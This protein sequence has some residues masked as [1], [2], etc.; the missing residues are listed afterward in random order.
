MAEKI[1]FIL[2]ATVK[3]AKDI[4]STTTATERLTQAITDQRNE[5]A[6]VNSQLK[7]AEGYQSAVK[8]MAKLQQQAK[9]SEASIARLGQELDD[10]KAHTNQL[11]VSYSKAQAELKGLNNQLKKTSGDGAERL[12]L[13]IKDTELRMSSLNTEIHESKVKTTDLNKAF[14]SATARSAK[15]TQQQDKQRDK[16]KKLGTELKE[17]GINTKRMAD[18]QRRLEQRSEKATAAIAKQNAHLK[19]MQV[20][21][22]RIDQ[23]KA[24][25]G[26][27]GGKATSLA[28]AAAPIAGSIWS[29]VKN[30]ASFA[31]VKKVFNGTPEEANNLREWSLK[32]AASKEGGGLNSN[33]INALLQAGAQS[34]IQGEKELKDFVLD[35]AKMG[36]AFDMDAEKAGE[37]LAVWKASLG[38]DHA[39][40][41]NLAGLANYLSNNSN[42]KAK[43]VAGV[44]A[45]QGASAKMAGFSVNEATALSATMLSAGLGEERSATALK[46]I[47]GRLTLG[48]A[49][50][51]S[52]QQA[53]AAIGFD[54]VELAASMQEDASGTFLQVLEAIK[55]APL[56]EQSALMSQIFGEESKGAV[57]A[58]AGNMGYFQ[59]MLK[60]A[61]QEQDVHLKSLQD[62]FN[63][64]LATSGVGISIFMNKLN[65]L[66]IVVGKA[67]LPVLDAVLVPLGWMVDRLADLAEANETVT[68]VIGTGITA[69]IGFKAAMLGIK[70]L[71]LFS[72]NLLDKGRLFRKGLN[73][74]TE[75]SGKAAQFAARQFSRLSDVLRDTSRGGRGGRGGGMGGSTRSNRST[76]SR[77]SRSRKPLGRVL[78]FASSAFTH[79]RGA[80]PLSLGGG[81]L[82]LTPAVA[83]AQDAIDVTGDI[84]EGAGKAG[85]SRILRPLSMA[86][87]AGNIATAISQGDTKGAITEGGGLL[88]GMGGASL[89][90]ALGTI[91]MPGIGTVAGGIVGSLVGD[92]GG[93]LLGGWFGDKLMDPPD[94]LMASTEVKDKL[95]EKERKEAI[96]RSMP[97]IQIAQTVN[98]APGMDEQQLANLVSRQMADLLDQQFNN[99]PGLSI[100]DS[101]SVSYIDRG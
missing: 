55:D 53:L 71:R 16:L 97:P 93:E 78:N 80:L 94:K 45:R 30:E 85:L 34:G 96:A 50:S 12:K 20:I 24:K 47:S 5:I 3:G 48:A 61:N 75:E 63:A 14:K 83:M 37:T 27:I 44:M 101:L 88:G 87:S 42:A 70:A 92:I 56:E 46:N 9:S 74:E 51:G 76:R 84:A 28:V 69:L 18:E 10:Q 65:R 86:I 73:R 57:A 90:A 33:D 41:M 64:V 98:A 26:E 66:S 81:A 40:A 2:D 52:Q 11:R 91:L 19:Q 38:L 36:V 39:E 17:S 77:R 35:S 58:L 67:L 43:D 32:V 99:I 8:R 54:S 49:A 15:L 22:G 82:A 79:N 100:S 31:G 89:G 62:E 1:S 29:A 25:L 7:K 4:V 95:V 59:K 68:T 23:R 21:Q 13:Q 6:S 60:L 72:G